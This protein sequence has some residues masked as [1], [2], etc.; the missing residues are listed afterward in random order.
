MLQHNADEVTR[1]SFLRGAGA[2][3]VGLAAV[4]SVGLLMKNTAIATQAEP[5]KTAL[6]YV[7]LDPDKAREIGYTKYW[8]GNCGLG[9]AEA[10]FGYLG[11]K[12]GAPYNQIPMHGFTAFGGGGNSW[13]MTCGALIG[14]MACIGALCTD[15]KIRG[16]MLDELLSWYIQYPFPEYQPAGLNLPKVVVGSP[17]CHVSV[18]RWCNAAG[19]DVNASS[20]EKKERCAGLT[21]DV[22]K[23]TIEILNAYAETG[24]FT[25][26]HKP[27]PVVASCMGCHKESPPYTQGKD[28][29]MN[30]H[31][32][33]LI[34][35]EDCKSH[36]GLI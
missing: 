8:D 31:G 18:S 15:K 12:L 14:P 35:I 30:C 32:S 10:T 20:K 33:T 22:C 7:K 36:E 6:P 17:L 23:K 2:S 16:Q 34:N 24:A 29:C 5:A 19:V 26:V 13:G 4:G 11:E 28:N 3:V 1:R 27:D 21:G 9:G 25:A